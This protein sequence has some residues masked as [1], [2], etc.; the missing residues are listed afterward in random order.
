M[1]TTA[2]G[3]EILTAG[4]SLTV[5]LAVAVA[6]QLFELVNVTVK[7]YPPVLLLLPNVAWLLV[8]VN[9]PPLP[10]QL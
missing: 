6:L 1:Q 9:V 4:N 3:G 7:L 5:A 8:L 10:A 2:T